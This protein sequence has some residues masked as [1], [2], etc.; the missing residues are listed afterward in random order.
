MPLTRYED[1]VDFLLEK[2]EDTLPKANYRWAKTSGKSGRYPCKWIPSTDRMYERLGEVALT[3]M[4]L[5]SCDFKGD[6]KNSPDDVMLM[7]TAPVPYTSGFIAHS[8]ADLLGVPFV[9]PLEE[10]E[11]MEFMDRIANG[12]KQGMEVGIDYFY[13]LASVLAKMGEAFEKGGGSKFSS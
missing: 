12:F 8:T 9:P 4:I 13:G 11:K 10:A 7:G 1:Y 3:G 2:R 6:V 5:S